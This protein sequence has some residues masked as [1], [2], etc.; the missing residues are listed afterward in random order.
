MQFTESNSNPKSQETWGWFFV[1]NISFL[2]IIN[3]LVVFWIQIK[4][5]F[6]SC[7]GIKK[8]QTEDTEE[9][10]VE[11]VEESKEDTSSDDSSSSE[12]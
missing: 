3:I 6:Q 9:P 12:D 5:S 4:N 2:T 11:I 7:C 10:K 8:V 1:F